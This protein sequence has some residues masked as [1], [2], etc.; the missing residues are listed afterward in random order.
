MTTQDESEFRLWETAEQPT[1]SLQRR[2]QWWGKKERR[3]D[4]YERESTDQGLYGS[5]I[6]HETYVFLDLKNK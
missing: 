1:Q 5:I 3:I 6:I 4:N 2:Q